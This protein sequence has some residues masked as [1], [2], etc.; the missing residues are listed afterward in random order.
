MSIAVDIQKLNRQ[1]EIKNFEETCIVTTLANDKLQL[2]CENDP[3]RYFLHI[4]VDILVGTDGKEFALYACWEATKLSGCFTPNRQA[5]FGFR[6]QA[7]SG[8]SYGLLR[9]E[10]INADP[11]KNIVR[12][13]S[14][15]RK[16]AYRWS[17]LGGWGWGPT[18]GAAS[19]NGFITLEDVFEPGNGWLSEG[20]L[21]MN[22]QLKLCIKTELQSSS[23]EAVQSNPKVSLSTDFGALLTTGAHAD[24][25]I[26]VKD[27][28]IHAHSLILAARSSVFASMFSLPMLEA[29]ERI[30]TISDLSMV[31]V[32]ATVTFMYTGEVDAQLLK[33]DA[34][35]LGIL[36]AAH[37]YTVPSLVDLCV[38]SLRS[39]LAVDTVSEWLH[40]ADL[41]GDETLKA[42]CLKFVRLHITE[43]Q[44]TE[45]FAKFIATRREL[46]AQILESL[47]PPAKRQRT[48]E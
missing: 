13:F 42:D 44:S 27:E 5:K 37:R 40:V 7:K 15:I 29:A 45:G 31:V 25:V 11:S 16:M 6:L 4:P 1:L 35:C 39:R 33:S 30:V 12:K 18:A 41:I 3:D 20:T 34:D 10:M 8:Q 38:Q 22:I 17:P 14:D 36:E 43:V 48:E 9:L 26:K 47:F 23:L 21:R 32:K 28:E 46:L 24:V 19:N 2:I